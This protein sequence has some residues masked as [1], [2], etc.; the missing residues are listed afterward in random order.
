MTSPTTALPLRVF[1]LSAGPRS[2]RLL[3]VD[4][5]KSIREVY[6][7]VCALLRLDAPLTA[8]AFHRM[9]ERRVETVALSTTAPIDTL[10]LSPND[11]LIV[12]RVGAATRPSTPAAPGSRHT[13]PLSSPRV[14]TARSAHEDVWRA[15]DAVVR[16][17]AAGTPT[18]PPLTPV[19]DTTFGGGASA[20]PSVD[21]RLWEC[22]RESRRG[23][24]PLTPLLVRGVLQLTASLS[25]L[26]ADI[27]VDGT[28][29]PL[30]DV[31][32]RILSDFGRRTQLPMEAV[33]R[34]LRDGGAA[35]TQAVYDALTYMV[36]DA[37]CQVDDTWVS[38]DAWL[39]RRIPAL[40]PAS[41]LLCILH[42]S[43][44]VE[45]VEAVLLRLLLRRPSGHAWL[46]LTDPASS[47]GVQYYSAIVG[48][49]QAA[50]P[51]HVRLSDIR[52][53]RVGVMESSCSAWGLYNCAYDGHLPSVLSWTWA[54]LAAAVLTGDA[55]AAARA[56][57]VVDLYGG[58]EAALALTQ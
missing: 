44:V 30:A 32:R 22:C 38:V 10:Q 2:A 49:A 4:S 42:G 34:Q 1:E 12:R 7:R 40:R 41:R 18:P 5:A 31:H 20:Q 13:T 23:S 28:A 52:V 39:A 19:S 25:A 55:D 57:D 16:A 46:A 14:V 50:A 6:P 11:I 43:R 3:E 47:G 27:A 48:L 9:V 58:G 51:T 8:F 36:A 24:C 37:G 35:E 53:V 21:A 33:Q 45:Y 54:A 17:T 29:S 15:T 26:P 56:R